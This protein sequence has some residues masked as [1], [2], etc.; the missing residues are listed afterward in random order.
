MAK[1][2]RKDYS[3]QD[4]LD[5]KEIEEFERAQRGEGPAKDGKPEDIDP[6]TQPDPDNKEEASWKKRYGDQRRHAQKEKERLEN[7]IKEL[8]AAK[9]SAEKGQIKYP[10]TEQELQDWLERYPKLAKIFD[11]IVQKRL[12][13]GKEMFSPDD[14]IKELQE[15]LEARDTEE[16]KKK[17]WEK[18]VKKHPDFPELVETEEFQDW[19]SKSASWVQDALWVNETDADVAIDA[20]DLYRA[21]NPI[22]KDRSKEREQA[23]SGVGQR[24]AP[25]AP[26]G[27]GKPTFTESQVERMSI[28]EYELREEEIEDAR[29][30]GRFKYDLTAAA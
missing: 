18:I 15:R 1:R 28:K 21:R 27:S 13:E 25:E 7:E 6:D 23:A 4:E 16:K 10:A 5:D 24:N 19:I 8:R 17:A 3:A 9:E 26:S 14:R 12:V 30:N 11:T 2:Y 22:K 29:R 20:I